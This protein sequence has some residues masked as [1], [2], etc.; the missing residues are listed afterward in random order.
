VLI[1]VDDRA[2]IGDKGVD[3]LI[4]GRSLRKHGGSRQEPQ[5]IISRKL[6][7]SRYVVCASEDYLMRFGTPRTPADLHRHSCIAHVSLEH[8][9]ADEWRFAKSHVRQRIKFVPKLRIQG[10]D[11]VCEAGVAG[12]GIISL[13]VA[14]I[15]E[16]L[17]SKRLVSLLQDWDRTGITPM[18]AIYR[19]TRPGLPQLIAFVSSLAQYFSRYNLK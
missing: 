12:C 6:F 9:V 2:E 8:D 13:M 19:K 3:V 1:S 15:E 17:R 16:E 14:N 7:Q 18:L 10:A 5:A 11:A 4:R